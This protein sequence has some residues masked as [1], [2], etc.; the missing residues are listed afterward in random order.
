MFSQYQL[1]RA[2]LMA[3]AALYAGANAAQAEEA[4][5][6]AQQQ[7][8]PEVEVIQKKSPAAKKAAPVAKKQAA[9]APSPQPQPPPPVEVVDEAPAEPNPIYGSPA[10]PARKSRVME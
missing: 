3:G 4:A 9:P 10:R 5:E 1:T 7:P 8:L 2:L 6:P